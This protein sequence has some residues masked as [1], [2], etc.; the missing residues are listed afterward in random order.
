MRYGAGDSPEILLQGGNHGEAE[1]LS[2]CYENSL[3]LAAGNNLATVAFPAISTGV[4]GYPKRA[5]SPHSCKRYP[6]LLRGG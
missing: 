1:K 2:A 4:Y 3:Q 6:A 5:S